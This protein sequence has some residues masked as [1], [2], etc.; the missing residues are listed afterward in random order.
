VKDCRCWSWEEGVV[1]EWGEDGVDCWWVGVVW[2]VEVA[3]EGRLR[4]GEVVRWG[5]RGVE[6]DGC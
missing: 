5:Y 2:C 3:E 4:W 6:G 1:G